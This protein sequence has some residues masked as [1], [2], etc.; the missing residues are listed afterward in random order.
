VA[1]HGENIAAAVKESTSEYT[2]QVNAHLSMAMGVI[3]RKQRLLVFF[4]QD[5]KQDCSSFGGEPNTTDATG[6]SG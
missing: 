4:P 5:L 2:L 1:R 6:K 3:R